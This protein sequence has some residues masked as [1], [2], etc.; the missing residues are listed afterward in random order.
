MGL[1][2]AMNASLSGLRVTQS[3]LEVVSNNIAN[4]DSVGYTRRQLDVRQRVTGDR[5][6]GVLSAGEIGR[7]SCRERV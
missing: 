7:A 4:A 3:Q 5:T 6:S 2:G 1:M